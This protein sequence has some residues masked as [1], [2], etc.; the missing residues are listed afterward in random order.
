MTVSFKEVTKQ[1]ADGTIALDRLNPVFVLGEFV[2]LLWLSGS[3][4][5]TDCR[6]LAGLDA[7]SGG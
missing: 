5:T 2:E 7:P 4:K 6:L 3:A 1:F